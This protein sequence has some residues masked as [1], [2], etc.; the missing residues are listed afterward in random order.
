M[1]TRLKLTIRYVYAPF[2][3]FIMSAVQIRL[4]NYQGEKVKIATS[5]EKAGLGPRT[6]GAKQHSLKAGRLK[7]QLFAYTVT[8]Q[9]EL[10]PARIWQDKLTVKRSMPFSN[11]VFHISFDLSMKSEMEKE[12]SKR[13]FKRRLMRVLLNQG[14]MLMSRSN[15]WIRLRKSL[16]CLNTTYSVSLSV[17]RCYLWTKAHAI[18]RLRRDGY[19]IRIC[20]CLVLCLATRTRFCF[21]Q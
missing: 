11:L 2:G 12:V 10:S 18:S 5:A 21:N 3:Q 16:L 6:S 14:R 15:F 9:G 20:R 13:R 1:V 17:R 4:T 7:G 8:N 19:S